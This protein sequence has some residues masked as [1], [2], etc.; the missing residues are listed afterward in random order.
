MP[1]NSQQFTSWSE[2]YPAD[3]LAQSVGLRK[4]WVWDVV[5]VSLGW[6]CWELEISNEWR[7]TVKIM[8]FI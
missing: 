1:S 5:D 2:A 4:V 3:T 8:M 6:R 7:Q